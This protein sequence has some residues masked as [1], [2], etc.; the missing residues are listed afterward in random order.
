MGRKEKQ[1]SQF[2]LRAFVFCTILFVLDISIGALLRYLYFKQEFGFMHATTYAIDSTRADI[3]VFGSSTANHHYSPQIFEK[4][5]KSSLYNAGRDGSGIFYHYSIL[6]GMLKRYTPKIAI[7]DFDIGEFQKDQISYDRMS[8]LLPYYKSHPEIKQLIDQRSSFEKFKL[9]S[10]IYPFNSLIFSVI[11]KDLNLNREEE[12][13]ANDNGFIP[14]Q[15]YW[16]MPLTIDTTKTY[17]LDDKEIAVF[18]SFVK[19][20]LNSHIKLY[21]VISPRFEKRETEDLSVVIAKRIANEYNMPIFNYLDDSSFLN[22]AGQFADKLH[23]NYIGAKKFSNKV[24]DSILL[25]LTKEQK[26]KFHDKP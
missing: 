26:S 5:M 13:A 1:I 4:R 18:K 9:L 6:L 16:K 7:F 25:D 11:S 10:K 22:D 2:F 17:D 21:I 15:R 8:S 3:I 12:E 14:L 24:A 19:L 23:L 20:C